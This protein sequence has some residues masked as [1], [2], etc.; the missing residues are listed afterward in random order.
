MGFHFQEEPYDLL[1]VLPFP[2]LPVVAVAL[3][4]EGVVRISLGLILIL[5]LLGYALIAALF[6]SGEDVVWTL[7]G[8]VLS[9]SWRG[10]PLRRAGTSCVEDL[11]LQSC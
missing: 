11:H 8:W 10:F 2:I 4:A 1:V 6:P 9:T 5:F 7:R 3:V